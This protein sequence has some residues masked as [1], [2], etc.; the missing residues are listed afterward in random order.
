MDVIFPPLKAYLADR[1]QGWEKE[2]EDE[3]GKEGGL[4]MGGD[5]E[6]ESNQIHTEVGKWISKY[7]SK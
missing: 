6:G 5:G 3:G 7:I 2:E 4:F 1:G